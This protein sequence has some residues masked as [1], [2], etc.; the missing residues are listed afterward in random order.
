MQRK[1]AK[2]LAHRLIGEHGLAAYQKTLPAERIARRKH[3]QIGKETSRPKATLS[4]A[5]AALPL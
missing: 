4:S 2:V 1:A 5:P 3:D